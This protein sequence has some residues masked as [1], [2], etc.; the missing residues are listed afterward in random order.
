MP[1]R[2]RRCREC[3]LRGRAACCT[4]TGGGAG[5]GWQ[6]TRGPTR[7][8]R[9]PGSRATAPPGGDHGKPCGSATIS[10]RATHSRRVARC[11]GTH[12]YAVDDGGHE[13]LG[14]LIGEAGRGDRGDRRRRGRA[15]V[16]GQ[17]C[18]LLRADPK[19]RPG[20][21]GAAAASRV[22]KRPRPPAEHG[23]RTW[24]RLRCGAAAWCSRVRRPSALGRPTGPCSG[25]GSSR[26]AA[27]AP[28]P[29][30]I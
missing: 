5:P 23:G 30:G 10:I 24:Q 19:G 13:Q 2:R 15:H 12:R 7:P 16:V 21:G 18:H 22:S 1:P 6:C 4:A 11:R 20:N 27:P 25:P 3:R 29:P 8:R 26:A 17:P 14:V 28:S 9:A